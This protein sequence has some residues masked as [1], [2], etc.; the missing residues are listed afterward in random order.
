[1]DSESPIEIRL[2]DDLDFADLK[3]ARDPNTGD[4]SFDWAA[5]ER[6]CE[7]SGLDLSVLEKDE[8]NVSELIIEWYAVHRA[9]DGAPDPVQE[10]L[11]AEAAEDP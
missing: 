6:I 2:P 10:A 3:L 1:M 9:R 11:I 5:L 8:D 4:L 7:A